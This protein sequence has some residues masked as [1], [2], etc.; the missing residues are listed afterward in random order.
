MSLYKMDDSLKVS[1][2]L[3]FAVVKIYEHEKK[4]FPRILHKPYVFCRIFLLPVQ[5]IKH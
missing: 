4:N 3:V 2:K 1:K 5:K